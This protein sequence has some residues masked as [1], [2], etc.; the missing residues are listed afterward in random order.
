MEAL[1]SFIQGPFEGG[2]TPQWMWFRFYPSAHAVHMKGT[3]KNIHVLL[4]KMRYREHRWIDY[5]C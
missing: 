2:V 3:Y 4:W 1:H 5:V